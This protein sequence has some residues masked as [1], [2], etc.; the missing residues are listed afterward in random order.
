MTGILPIHSNSKNAPT[1]SS[2][3]QLFELNF[4]CNKI[5]TMFFLYKRADKGRINVGAHPKSV[6]IDAKV[7]LAALFF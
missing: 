2:Q 4:L 7:F 3:T 1:N 6:K 5:N